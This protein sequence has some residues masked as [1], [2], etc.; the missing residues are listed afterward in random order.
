METNS[1]LLPF[2]GTHWGPIVLH[3]F[4]MPQKPMEK[5]VGRKNDS[6]LPIKIHNVKFTKG[7]I[8]TSA[9]EFREY[10]DKF[11]K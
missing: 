6:P 11:I 4:Q 1:F 7:G 9:P 8:Q 2:H 10:Y 5:T 3:S